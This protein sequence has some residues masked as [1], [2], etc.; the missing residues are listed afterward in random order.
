MSTPALTPPPQPARPPDQPPLDY[1]PTHLDLP[2]DDGAIVHNFQEHPQAMLLSDGIDP[3]LRRRHPNRDYCIGQ[4]CGIYW[5]RVPEPPYWRVVAPDWFYVP[6][7]PPR[8]DDGPFR[9]SFVL[10]DEPGAPLILLEFASGDGSEERDQ[11]PEKGKFWIYEHIIRPPFYGI[12]LRNPWRIEMYEHVVGRF[13]QAEPNASGR[14]PI[15]PLGLELG[16]WTGEHQGTNATWMRWY[17]SDGTLL[18]VGHERADAEARRA[19]EALQ[20]AEQERQLKEKYAAKLRE[21]GVNPDQ[22]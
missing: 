19:Q 9:R 3:I 4:D 1:W 12:F 5:R 10:W 18:P 2:C 8:G 16:L 7:V 15:V 22:L 14:Y 17:A 21:L 6:D 20:L 13:V 11:T